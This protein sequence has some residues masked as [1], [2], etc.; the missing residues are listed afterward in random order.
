MTTSL[1]TMGVAPPVS[2][3]AVVRKAAKHS[4]V[5]L[6]STQALLNTTKQR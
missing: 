5:V 4:E 3:E 1:R 2:G 6:K